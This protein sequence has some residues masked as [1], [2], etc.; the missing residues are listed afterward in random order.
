M[1]NDYNVR[2]VS[3]FQ[4]KTMNTIYGISLESIFEA[5]FHCRKGHSRSFVAQRFEAHYEHYL[6]ELHREICYGVYR[7]KSFTAFVVTKPDYREVFAAEFR[8]RV[9]L[10]WIA[11][12]LMPLIDAQLV[13]CVFNG[14]RGKGTLAAQMYAYDCIREVSNH[15]TRPCYVMK[16]DIKGFFMSIN[17]EFATDL[18]CRFVEE[19]YHEADADTLLYLL[20][21]SLTTE[22]EKYCRRVGDVSLWQHIPTHKSLFTCGDGL[23]LPIGDSL[24]QI[25]SLLILDEVHHFITDVCGLRM[26]AYADDTFIC[27][28]SRAEL[29]DAVGPIRKMLAEIG[30]TLHPRKFYFQQSWKG[31][32]FIGAVLMHGRRYVSNRT[33]HNA[34]AK[35]RAYNSRARDKRYRRI[36]IEHLVASVNS[37]LGIM[38]HHSSRNIRRRLIDSIAPEWKQMLCIDS[39]YN[40]ILPKKRYRLREKIKRA[41]RKQRR[42]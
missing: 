38:R 5:Y 24:T 20:R 30:I 1:N 25:V 16:L 34:F 15:Y 32:K 4:E 17:R 23:G 39:N 3:E 8:H 14:R 11:L 12:R 6:V 36:N 40:K 31:V 29:L 19:R 37:Y 27:A 18:V 10:H 41:T 9:V 22:P 26:A 33:V 13:D 42:L 28:N 7:P 2:A 35:V 21:V